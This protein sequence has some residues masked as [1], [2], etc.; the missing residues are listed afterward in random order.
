MTYRSVGMD[1]QSVN[2][3]LVFALTNMGIASN[4]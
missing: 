3:R 4:T 1:I 2:M